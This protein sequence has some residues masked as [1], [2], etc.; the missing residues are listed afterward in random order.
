MGRKGQESGLLGCELL[1][2]LTTDVKLRRF[3]QSKNWVESFSKT[4]VGH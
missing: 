1:S 2:P 4:E 3:L